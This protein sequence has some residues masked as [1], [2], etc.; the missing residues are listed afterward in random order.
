VILYPVRDPA[1]AE[2]LFTHLL[3]AQPTADSPYYPA[4][5]STV[6]KSASSRTATPAKG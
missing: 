1:K 2:E 6:S 5:T 4:T 3:G